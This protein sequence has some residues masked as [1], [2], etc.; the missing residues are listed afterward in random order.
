MSAYLGGGSSGWAAGEVGPLEAL[1]SGGE[2]LGANADTQLTT[3]RVPIAVQMCPLVVLL[4]LSWLVKKLAIVSEVA[5]EW[6][7]PG[8]HDSR[9]RSTT[10]AIQ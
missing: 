3:K 6:K 1:S 8:M 2:S 4:N 7:Q 9:I 5:G 10:K